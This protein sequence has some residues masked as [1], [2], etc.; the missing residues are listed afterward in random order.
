MKVLSYLTLL[1][2]LTTAPAA[3]QLY[4]EDG[5]S[6]TLS[7][8]DSYLYANGISIEPGGTLT[9]RGTVEWV[10]QATTLGAIVF[11]IGGDPASDDYGRMIAPQNDDIE[12]INDVIRTELVDGF[13]PAA[14]AS[15]QLI[16]AGSL[17]RLPETQELPGPLWSYRFTDAEVFAEFD[18]TA[19]PVEWL[20]FTGRWVGKSARLDWQTAAEVDADYF[21]VERQNTAGNWTAIGQV[22]A[23]GSPTTAGTYDLLDPTPGLTNPVLYRLRQ[24]D[25]NGDFNYSDIV[26]LARNTGDAAVGLF[27]NPAHDHFYVEGLNAGTFTITDAAGRQVARGVIND[28]QRFRIDLPVGLPP[29][30]YFLYPEQGD[31]QRFTVAR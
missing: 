25:Y 3:A 9:V 28:A 4:I 21:S 23:V 18:E 11:Q 2:L 19:L 24:V 7:K 5:G 22:A 20:G 17:D 12:F 14:I 30:T 8:Q 1:I 10:N 15:Y 16:T 29:G 13:E 26:S 27:P 31:A 6:L